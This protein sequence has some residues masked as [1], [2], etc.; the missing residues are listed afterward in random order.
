MTRPT[1]LEDKEI[2]A[3]LAAH[4]GWTSE[5]GAAIARA[6][7]FPDFSAA[8]AFVVRVG[9]AAEKK[10]H[11]PDVELGWGKARVLWSTHDA[12]GITS[13]DLELAALTDSF[14]QTLGK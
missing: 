10:D 2:E 11:H 9:L 3:W 5:K 1:K 4:P 12:G 14:A 7:K 13:L 6:F 8:L